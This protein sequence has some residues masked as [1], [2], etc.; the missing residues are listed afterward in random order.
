MRIIAIVLFLVVFAGTVQAADSQ[1]NAAQVQQLVT[2][3]QSA[4]AGKD[5]EIE[6][7]V[8]GKP[9][10]FKV[11]KDGLGNVTARPVITPGTGDSA[12]SY[13]SIQVTYSDTGAVVPGVVT[14]A[15]ANGTIQTYTASANPDGTVS[16]V[17]PTGETP[18]PP[19]GETPPSPSPSPSPS[20]GGQGTSRPSP[21]PQAPLGPPPGAHTDDMSP[22]RR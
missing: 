16:N 13:V 21:S 3:A 8:D 6:L 4:S 14:M 17:K 10:K 1:L 9:I 20:S 2:A 18:P 7:I 19:P 12:I 15:M 5:A 22:A 11:S